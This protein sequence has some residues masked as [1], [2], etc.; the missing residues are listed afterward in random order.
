MA[1]N[2]AVFSAARNVPADCRREITCGPLKGMTDINPVWRFEKLTELFGPC[3]IGWWY[4]ITDKQLERLE[5]TDTIRAFVDI[6]LYY[7]WNG[8]ISRPVPGTG[9]ST[10]YDESMDKHGDDECF[11]K[12]LTDA[13]SVACKALGIGAD[14]Y[15]GKN[16]TDSGDSKYCTE[17]NGLESYEPDNS[18]LPFLQCDTADREKS[19]EAVPYY[20]TVSIGGARTAPSNSV[21]TFD[22]ARQYVIQQG[23]FAGRTIW[24]ANAERPEIVRYYADNPDRYKT[25]G[26]AA[27]VFLD[28][29][30]AA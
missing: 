8:E 30:G 14:V 24:E 3:G 6:K 9:G 23:K 18:D 22:E 2:L 20:R 25:L 29:L 7:V 4:E 5:N 16:G 21:M 12:A 17:G 10:F 19:E 1:D 15:Y 13:I 28:G 27:K 26:I 11:K